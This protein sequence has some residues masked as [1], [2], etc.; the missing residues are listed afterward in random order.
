MDKTGRAV[1]SGS[2]LFNI[3]F[4]LPRTEKNIIGSFGTF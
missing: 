4:G 1:I 2:R 3:V